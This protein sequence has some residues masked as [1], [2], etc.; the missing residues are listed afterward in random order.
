[1]LAVSTSSLKVLLNVYSVNIVDYTIFVNTAYHHENLRSELID[2]GRSLLLRDGYAHFSLR[3]LAKELGVSHTAPYRH[4][5]SREAL[6]EAIVREDGEGFNRALAA[7]VEGLTDPYERLYCLGEAYVLFFVDNP[8]VLLL[9]SYL[10]GQLAMQG[11]RIATLFSPPG[12]EDG[13]EGTPE[14]RDLPKDEGYA[15][16]KEA[17]RPFADRFQGLSD[18][19]ILLGYW[20]KVHGL[21]NLLVNQK[22]FI[23]EESLRERIRV[24]V[25][26][27]F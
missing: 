12:F 14:C 25:R 15:L 7:G 1:M 27:P 26:T 2:K 5:D 18:R 17:A 6:I 3:Q 9:F 22:G 19:E 24:L 13:G 16:L 4:F 23:P 11:E 20:A 10:P 21:A 8:E